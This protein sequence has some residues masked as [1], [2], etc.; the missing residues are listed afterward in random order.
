MLQLEIV[1]ANT[2]AIWLVEPVYTIGNG[3]NDIYLKEPGLE[4]AHLQLQVGER[5]ISICE[6]GASSLPIYI[7]GK[8]LIGRDVL[9]HGDTLTVG[10]SRIE[11]TDSQV[12][13]AAESVQPLDIGSHWH[14]LALSS[15]LEDHAFAISND[16]IL[17]RDAQ[18]DIVLRSQHVSKRQAR[19]ITKN[20]QLAIIDLDSS[21]GTFV[22][23]QRIKQR[24][25]HHGDHIM[26]GA[27][28]FKLMAPLVHTKATDDPNK[29]QLRAVVV[30]KTSGHKPISANTKAKEHKAYKDGHT[31]QI[32]APKA[33]RSHTS[34]FILLGLIVVGAL[35]TVGFV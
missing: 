7:N 3:A 27:L 23:K 11:I 16:A 30:P 9:K 10:R 32:S 5:H 13:H 22:N 18:C 12:I 17:G 25:L 34:L 33:K 35:I 2:P 28:P 21:N 29:T 15:A 31:V 4:E 14:L 1:S 6:L 26:F 24:V 20:N 8:V 19:F